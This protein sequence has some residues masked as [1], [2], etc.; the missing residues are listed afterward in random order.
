MSLVSFIGPRP[1]LLA[2]DVLAR[3]AEPPMRLEVAAADPH[4]REHGEA[5]PCG[6][7]SRAARSSSIELD[8][9]YPAA[10]GANGM[11]AALASARGARRGR[12]PPGLQHPDPVRSQRVAPTCCRSPRCSPP[13]PCTSTWCARACARAPG[14]S[15]RPARRARCITSR[16]SRAMAPR[17]SIRTSRSRRSPRWREPIAATS[18]RRNSQKRFIKAICKGLYKV[19]SKMGI[20]TY[21]S[22]C[23]A[24]IFEAVGLAEARSSTSTSPARRATSKASA[25]SRSPRRRVRLHR[26]AFGDDPLL[27][28]RA[29]RGRRVLLPHPRRRAHVD[30][31]LDRE[32]AARGARE[33]R[34]DLPASTRR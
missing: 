5:P 1:N 19:M 3:R 18:S 13:R 25:C 33:Q 30:A 23:G 31:G 21:Q 9:C 7:C 22:Y 16:C 8:I 20:S 17:R 12:D 29:R 32:A 27:R 15:S 24:Q 28:Q 26:L 34:F 11:E 10:W 2:V 14:S 6:R 4:D